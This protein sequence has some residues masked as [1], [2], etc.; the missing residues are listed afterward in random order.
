MHTYD[1]S[2]FK[3]GWFIGNFEPA[4]HKTEQFE[5][6]HHT[7]AKGHISDNHYHKTSTEINYIIRGHLLVTG[8]TLKTGSIWIYEPGDRSEVEVMEQTDLIVIKF[9]SVPDDKFY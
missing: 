8:K 7:L 9:P 3:G 5:I 6:A 4:I 2:E 1:I